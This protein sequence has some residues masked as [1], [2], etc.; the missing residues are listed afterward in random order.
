MVGEAKVLV[1]FGMI[2]TG[3]SYLAAAWAKRHACSYYNSDRVRKEL[4]GLAPESRQTSA[5][6]QGIYSCEFSRRTYDHLLLLAERDLEK[7]S[8]NCVVLDGSYQAR[9]ERERVLKQLSE[10]GRVVF[11]HC[12]CPEDVM[13]TRMEQRQQDAQAVS[14]GRWEIYLQQKRRFEMPVELGPDQLITLNTNQ[15]LEALLIDLDAWM[16]KIV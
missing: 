6:D 10:K 15:P 7:S 2:A 9:D 3:K 12:V 8:G 13:R 1:F 4:A 11:V 14:D 5:V 16:E